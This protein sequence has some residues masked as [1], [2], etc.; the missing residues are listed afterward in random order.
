MTAP[1]MRNVIGSQLERAHT[2]GELEVLGVFRSVDLDRA[3]F[4]AGAR[5]HIPAESRDN[6][7]KNRRQQSYELFYHRE[8]IG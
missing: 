1:D 7:N 6:E 4:L 3:D 5:Y 8:P 2:C